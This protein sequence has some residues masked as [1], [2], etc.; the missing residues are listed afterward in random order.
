MDHVKGIHRLRSF[1]LATTELCKHITYD[2]IEVANLAGDGAQLLLDRLAAYG[3]DKYR[4]NP[5]DSILNP[6]N[7]AAE[8]EEHC[9][10]TKDGKIRGIPLPDLTAYFA[11]YSPKFQAKYCDVEQPEYMYIIKD[12]DTSRGDKVKRVR[13]SKDKNEEGPHDGEEPVPTGRSITIYL[14]Q[15]DKWVPKVGPV[16]EKRVTGLDVFV[17]DCI[18]EHKKNVVKI[19]G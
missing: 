7:N 19:L 9:K 12:P 5:E 6:K 16:I 14:P 1:R 11:V 8:L 3:L 13:F 4:V 18:D 15:G 10:N 2:P 17:R